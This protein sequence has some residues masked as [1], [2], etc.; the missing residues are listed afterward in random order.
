MEL[1]YDF[2]VF[3]V[4]PDSI[5][6]DPKLGGMLADL[7]FAQNMRANHVFLFRHQATAD[8][9]RTAPDDIRE[10]LLALGFGMNAHSSGC[11]DGFYPA[12]DQAIRMD[13]A[14]RLAGAVSGGAFPPAPHAGPFVLA[15]LCEVLVSAAPMPQP[16]VRSGP[17]RA[18]RV[19]QIAVAAAIA[20]LAAWT[21]G[22]LPGPELGTAM[23]SHPAGAL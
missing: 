23:V 5:Y 16:P 15:R 8:A 20:L 22:W 13:L 21:F 18:Q 3:R 9:L 14:Q 10:S 1:K 6:A 17:D 11:P 4:I 2:D 12:A 19:T 7:G